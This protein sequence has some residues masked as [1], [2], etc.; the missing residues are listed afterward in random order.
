ME[1]QNI[2]EDLESEL[3]KLLADCKNR[4]SSTR[5]VFFI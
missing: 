2:I 4:F 1:K 5:E 3:K